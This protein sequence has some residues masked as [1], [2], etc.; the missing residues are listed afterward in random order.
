V[1]CEL[2]WKKSP[3]HMVHL[4]AHSGAAISDSTSLERL[5]NVVSFTKDVTASGVGIRPVRSSVA[6]RTNSK[7]VVGGAGA[8]PAS[9]IAWNRYLSMLLAACCRVSVR[10]PPG[11]DGIAAVVIGALAAKAA[12]TSAAGASR[13]ATSTVSVAVAISGWLPTYFS[14][15][16]PK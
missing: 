6:R 3:N 15:F 12:I 13:V 14:R 7:S 1:L 4:S 9:A 10:L 5:S 8:T 2:F 11:A 16:G